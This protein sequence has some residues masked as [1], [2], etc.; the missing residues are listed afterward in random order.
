MQNRNWMFSAAALVLCALATPAGAENTLTIGLAAPL[1]GSYAPYN[2]ARGVQCEADRINKANEG[3]TVKVLMED[4]RSDP[5]LTLSLAQKYLDDK[6]VV[7][8]GT[9]F[10]DSLIPMAKM[11]EAYNALV[12]S[13]Q[14]TQVEMHESGLTNFLANVVPDDVG[15]S[16][17]ASAVYAKGARSVVLMTSDSAGS[18]SA[19]T[20]EWFGEAFEKLGGKVVGRLN[21][22]IGTSDWSP[23]VAN[24]QAM[25][26]QPDAVDICSVVPDVAILA[27]QLT[28][29]GY[30]GLVV[31][32]DGFDDPSLEATV[33]DNDVLSRMM[34]NTHAA[35]VGTPAGAF[36]ES[37]KADGYKVNGIFDA[38][39]A[40]MLRVLVDGAKDAGT[41]T[42]GAKILA[43]IQ[44]R[45]TFDLVTGGKISFKKRLTWPERNVP[46]IGFADG[47]RVLVQNIFPDFIPHSK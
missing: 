2:E 7:V 42:D 27:R 6:A 3:I 40:D 8:H 45:D 33:G 20:P 1:T 22:T 35:M 39:G 16:A 18:W 9:P 26:P 25:S 30:K 15:A 11:A 41:T 29:A 28:A 19:K 12:Y 4:S 23:Q 37:C 24:I 43:A 13:A 47:K 44:A 5:Q 10:P 32:C 36:I 14:I 31:G 21:H 46:V 17:L 34:F 38:L